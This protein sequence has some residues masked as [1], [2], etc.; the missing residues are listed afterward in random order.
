MK[1][2]ARRIQQSR[3]NPMSTGFPID[4]RTEI[5]LLVS[6]SELRHSRLPAK[7]RDNMRP[8]ET[9]SAGELEKLVFLRLALQTSHHEH[10]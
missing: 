4:P 6:T 10:D 5:E 8:L 1:R 2:P 9:L 3:A 7:D